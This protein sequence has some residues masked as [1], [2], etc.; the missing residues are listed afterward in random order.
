MII[1]R[2]LSSY[3]TIMSN[4]NNFLSFNLTISYST[5]YVTWL[6]LFWR[7]ETRS[8]TFLFVAFI[9]WQERFTSSRTSGKL[10]ILYRHFVTDFPL[11]RKFRS[12]TVCKP[13]NLSE[14]SVDRSWKVWLTVWR[15]QINENSVFKW[16][17]SVQ[18]LCHMFFNT[19]IL[20]N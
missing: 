4:V 6:W 11:R 10:Y 20:Q 7:L 12:A 14:F 17:V 18:S 3:P 5:C 2:L 8:I 13:V 15:K 1:S 16:L 9:L 19:F